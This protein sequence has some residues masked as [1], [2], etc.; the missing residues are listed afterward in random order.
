MK[1]ENVTGKTPFLRIGLHVQKLLQHQKPNL[2]FSKKTF[3][4]EYENLFLLL[5][6]DSN[7]VQISGENIRDKSKSL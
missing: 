5:S 3:Q 6:Y 7:P 4:R 2:C 1:Q